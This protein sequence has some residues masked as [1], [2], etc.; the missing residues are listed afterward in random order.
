MA[1]V[2]VLIVRID[3][4]ISLICTWLIEPERFGSNRKNYIGPVDLLQFY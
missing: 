2:L 3:L 4:G 1:N